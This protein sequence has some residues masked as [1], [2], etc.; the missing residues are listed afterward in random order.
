MQWRCGENHLPRGERREISRF[1]RVRRTMG[2]RSSSLSNAG[3]GKNPTYA[4][5]FATMST[6]DA[7]WQSEAAARQSGLTSLGA[8]D[9][10]QR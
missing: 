2:R 1:A 3:D 7:V 8:R 4:S 9:D 6:Y 5:V 10:S